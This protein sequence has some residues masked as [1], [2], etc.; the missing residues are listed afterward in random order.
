[1]ITAEVPEVKTN[2]PFDL[3]AALVKPPESYPLW[4]QLNYLAF[5]IRG[6]TPA[7]RLAEEALTNL[8]VRCK[9]YGVTSVVDG[10]RLLEPHTP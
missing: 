9:F 3:R 7:Q 4:S 5:V 6:D 2:E 8:A 10:L 1:M